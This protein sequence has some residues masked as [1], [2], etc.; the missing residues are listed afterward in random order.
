MVHG[1]ILDCEC[2]IS[3][4]I[5]CS[6]L[7]EIVPD[8]EAKKAI[9]QKMLTIEILACA[10]ICWGLFNHILSSG[11]RLQL[12][13]TAVNQQLVWQHMESV[14][15]TIWEKVC[16]YQVKKYSGSRWTQS[17]LFMHVRNYIKPDTFCCVLFSFHSLAQ[18]FHPHDEIKIKHWRFLSTTRGW[19]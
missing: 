12:L 17:L 1:I 6:F 18:R 16:R 3:H 9:K 14:I 7:E 13:H 11:N 5:C 4:S 8:Y 2:P 19:V 10:D 15:R